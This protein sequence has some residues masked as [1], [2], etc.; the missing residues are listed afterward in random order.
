MIFNRV[1]AVTVALILSHSAASAADLTTIGGANFS[2]S[3][4]Q[5]RA[6]FEAEGYR[7]E[8]MGVMD[9][10]DGKIDE[11]GCALWKDKFSFPDAETLSMWTM[12]YQKDHEM[13]IV[14]F[15]EQQGEDRV[16]MIGQA[17]FFEDATIEMSS[18]E[19]LGD[20]LSVFSEITPTF[21]TFDAS[22]DTLDLCIL[23]TKEATVLTPAELPLSA[24][25]ESQSFLGSQISPAAILC[26][27]WMNQKRDA[28]LDFVHSDAGPAYARKVLYYAQ[29]GKAQQY[30]DMLWDVQAVVDWH[31]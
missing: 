4:A 10:D 28:V 21:G 11:K 13:L 22:E 17:T 16:L 5:I 14:V 25:E 23:M 19:F 3:A 26:E 9:P 6:T 7:C 1:L 31:Q 24:L 30:M 18:S 12:R 2:Q 27:R 15:G 29:D 20:T 8:R